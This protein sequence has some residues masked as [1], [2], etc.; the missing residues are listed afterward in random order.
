MAPHL[1]ASAPNGDAWRAP[2]SDR[3][4]DVAQNTIFFSVAQG[5]RKVSLLPSYKYIETGPAASIIQPTFKWS[6]VHGQFMA[7]LNVSLSR[8]GNVT[9]IQRVLTVLV[10][11]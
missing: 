6:W 8:K 5:R 9:V 11:L 1:L 7:M 4:G 10:F 2:S 3:E